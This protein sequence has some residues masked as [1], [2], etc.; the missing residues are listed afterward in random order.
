MTLKE[1]E[2]FLPKVPPLH[3]ER[4]GELA[5]ISNVG[6]M[7]WCEVR[8]IFRGVMIDHLTGIDDPHGSCRQIIVDLVG[9]KFFFESAF[10]ASDRIILKVQYRS[11]CNTR[12]E[13]IQA[14]PYVGREESV[15]RIYEG[16]IRHLFVRP[17]VPY[18]SHL[19]AKDWKILPKSH[20]RIPLKLFHFRRDLSRRF[21]DCPQQFNHPILPRMAVRN[22]LNQIHYLAPKTP[23][24]N[25]EA[26]PAF[27]NILSESRDFLGSMTCAGVGVLKVVA[28]ESKFAAQVIGGI[29]KVGSLLVEGHDDATWLPPWKISSRHEILI[30]EEGLQKILL[31]SQAPAALAVSA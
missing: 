29:S 3:N 1:F 8:V 14:G 16:V 13:G 28:D 25:L 2:P 7:G 31:A 26:K 4:L 10:Q 5:Q 15:S 21:F 11:K 30:E 9:Y 20:A 18:I 23:K 12:S 22:F 6:W 24:E 17:S 27:R 19:G